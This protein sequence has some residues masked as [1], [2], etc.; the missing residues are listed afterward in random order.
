MYFVITVTITT[1]SVVIVIIR[2]IYIGSSAGGGKEVMHILPLVRCVALPP[3]VG[4]GLAHGGG[5]PYLGD[6]QQHQH[7]FSFSWLGALP[8]TF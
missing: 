1:I 3:T 7:T 2:R 6:Y 4:G 5:A 8:M